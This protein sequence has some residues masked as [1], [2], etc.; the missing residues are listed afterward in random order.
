MR[1]VGSLR[2]RLHNVGAAASFAVFAVIAVLWIVSFWRADGL[3]YA[4]SLTI[5]R[6]TSGSGAIWLEWCKYPVSFPPKNG[7]ETGRAVPD[8]L[9]L[10]SDHWVANNQWW[11]DAWVGITFTSK[12]D[13][14][15]WH[16][17]FAGFGA[18]GF[19]GKHPQSQLPYLLRLFLF[20]H[21]FF[22][23][24]TGVLPLQWIISRYRKAFRARNNRCVQCGYD[25]RATP[26]R[27]PECGAIARKTIKGAN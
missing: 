19:L 10:I 11:W 2:S 5:L 24:A 22:A 12:A 15:A 18:A 21:W 9:Y 25:L 14:T 4:H 6:A 13:R 27:C 26:D 16:W 17:R 3:E 1:D 7:D 20:P 8:G 23:V